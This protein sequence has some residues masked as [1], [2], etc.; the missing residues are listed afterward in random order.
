MIAGTLRR[1]VVRVVLAALVVIGL[2]RRRGGEPAVS[3]GRRSWRA[4]VGLPCWRVPGVAGRL[5]LIARIEETAV[6]AR[7]LRHLG[8]PIEIPAP[9]PAHHHA[10]PRS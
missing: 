8:L 2:P 9:R 6:I 7:I 4:P 5:R 1:A 3:V 10:L